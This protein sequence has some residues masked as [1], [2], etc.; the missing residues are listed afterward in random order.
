MVCWHDW[1][2]G[3]AVLRSRLPTEFEGVA[4]KVRLTVDNASSIKGLELDSKAVNDASSTPLIPATAE[5]MA[6]VFP[7]SMFPPVCVID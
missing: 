2:I 4:I 5:M 1:T 6:D 3:N 7:A